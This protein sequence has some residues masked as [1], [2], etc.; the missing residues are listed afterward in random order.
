MTV[1]TNNK[2]LKSA[3][4]D[5]DMKKLLYITL[6][7]LALT[8]AACGSAARSNSANPSSTSQNGSGGELPAT[9]Q[10]ALGTLKLDGTDNAVTAEQASELLP[11]WETLRDLSTSDTAAQQ[12]IQALDTQIQ[13]TMTDQQRQAITAMNL[14]RQDMFTLLQTQGTGL[15]NGQ[16]RTNSQNGNSTGNGNRNFAF[17]AGGPPPDG[18]GFPGGQGFGGQGQN[19]SAEQIATAQ[20]A[21]QAG[22]GNRISIPLINAVIE[23]LKKKAGS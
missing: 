5:I 12:E 14:T 15:G 10:I 16:Q 17:G 6:L 19:R 9:T 7:I 8:A 22:G 23:F 18:G 1:E 20:A 4:K 2:S 11:L 13:E 3:Y 21:R